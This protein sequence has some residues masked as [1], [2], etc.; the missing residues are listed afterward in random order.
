MWGEKNLISYNL[1]VQ[2]LIEL[3]VVSQIA[4]TKRL[5]HQIILKKIYLHFFTIWP[6]LIFGLSYVLDSY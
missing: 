4:Y 6:S 3:Y 1:R 2:S 5:H